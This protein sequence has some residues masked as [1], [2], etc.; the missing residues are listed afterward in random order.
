MILFIRG[1]DLIATPPLLCFFSKEQSSSSPAALLLKGPLLA[2]NSMQPSGAFV[3]T[4]GE[5]RRKKT[6]I[7]YPFT[8]SKINFP[9]ICYTRK[10]HQAHSIHLSLPVPRRPV[11]PIISTHTHVITVNFVQRREHTRVD[12]NIKKFWNQVRRS[13]IFITECIL[14]DRFDEE[15]RSTVGCRQPPDIY[16]DFVTQLINK[17]R[18]I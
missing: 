7:Y 8:Q 15:K 16:Q 14:V 6:S 2:L 10:L 18:R 11:R 17:Q 4:F 9:S 1:L 12:G 5:G 13:D 3:Y